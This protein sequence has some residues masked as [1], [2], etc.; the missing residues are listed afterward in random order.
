MYKKGHDAI[1]MYNV[2]AIEKEMKGVKGDVG[3]YNHTVSEG[4][5]IIKSKMQSS[6]KFPYLPGK[7]LVLIGTKTYNSNFPLRVHNWEA[8]A[9]FY[10]YCAGFFPYSFSKASLEE[11]YI[12]KVKNT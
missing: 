11:F 6:E 1:G 5:I 12:Y 4:D 2:S 3:I 8:R 7:K 9:G 10:S